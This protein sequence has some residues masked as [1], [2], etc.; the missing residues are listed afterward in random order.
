MDTD[1]HG[2]CLSLKPRSGNNKF[3]NSLHGTIFRPKTNA[4]FGRCRTLWSTAILTVW[5]FPILP[6]V[7]TWVTV[8]SPPHPSN[9]PRD[10]KIG[11]RSDKLS[12]QCL[13]L[14]FDLIIDMLT[15]K[16]LSFT[17]RTPKHIKQLLIKTFKRARPGFVHSARFL[18]ISDQSCIARPVPRSGH[19]SHCRELADFKLCVELRGKSHHQWIYFARSKSGPSAHYNGIAPRNYPIAEIVVAYRWYF[20]GHMSLVYPE[21]G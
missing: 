7:A 21:G 18:P 4:D 3:L 20:A 16:S 15:P 14:K 5:R 11:Y 19:L 2:R 1:I 10:S 8:L 12:R 13:R 9:C 6:D 17:I